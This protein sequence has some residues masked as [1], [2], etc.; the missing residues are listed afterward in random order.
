MDIK[1]VR[2]ASKDMA[3]VANS[4]L[5]KLIHDEKKYDKSIND[6]CIVESLYDNFYKNENVCILLAK[7]KEEYVGYLFGNIIDTGDA[8][9]IKKAKLDAMFV[10]ENYRGNKIGVRLIE[11]FKKWAIKKDIRVIELTVC[12]D[13][14][15]AIN[16]YEKCNFIKAKS[17]MEYHIG[18]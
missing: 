6:N 16:L 14:K 12:N 11:E 5:T 2:A 4:Y 8:Y 3:I 9:I 15:S 10:D 7:H 13:N 18:E 17:V 1:I